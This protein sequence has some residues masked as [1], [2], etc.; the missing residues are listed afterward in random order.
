[1]AERIVNQ[2]A[3]A[4][5]T[6]RSLDIALPEQGTRHTFTRGVQVDGSQAIA[7]SIGMEHGASRKAYLG[8][9][10]LLAIPAI[11]AA[12]ARRARKLA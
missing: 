2:Q 5:P 1:L 11:T 12:F 4:T 8:L 7:L 10:F 9:F 3:A 6:L